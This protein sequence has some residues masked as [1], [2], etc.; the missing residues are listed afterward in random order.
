MNAALKSSLS[1]VPFNLKAYTVKQLSELYGVSAKTF[2][3][4]LEPFAKSIG[5]KKGY[6]YNISQV[7]CI[8]S[9]LGAPGNIVVD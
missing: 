5:E 6:F 8:V 7:K 1:G 4:W 2:R 9:Y 3:R